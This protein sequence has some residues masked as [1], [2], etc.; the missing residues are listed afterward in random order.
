MLG[1]IDDDSVVS[2]ERLQ[3]IIEG[4]HVWCDALL[5]IHLNKSGVEPEFGDNRGKIHPIGNHSFK[6]EGEINIGSM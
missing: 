4:N 5:E 3:G 6:F 1:V 2:K